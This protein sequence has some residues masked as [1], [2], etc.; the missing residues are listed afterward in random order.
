MTQIKDW[1]STKHIYLATFF[2]KYTFSM[3]KLIYLNLKSTKLIN[4]WSNEKST[5]I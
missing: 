3:W 5:V 4:I 1:N 2:N